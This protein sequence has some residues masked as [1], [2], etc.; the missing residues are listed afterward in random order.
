M[1]S[2]NWVFKESLRFVF[3]ER[4]IVNSL[5]LF[6]LIEHLLSSLIISSSSVDNSIV[7]NLE[8]LEVNSVI[9]LV[10]LDQLLISAANLTMVQC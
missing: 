6:N 9:L 5:I 8:R 2:C 1:L 3:E 7:S 4:L 10:L